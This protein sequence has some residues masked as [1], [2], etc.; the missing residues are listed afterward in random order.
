MHEIWVGFILMTP[1]SY[2]FF[3]EFGWNFYQLRKLREEI[4]RAA[5]RCILPRNFIV[6]RSSVS[7]EPNDGGSE[8]RRC[9]K[10]RKIITLPETNL[11]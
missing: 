11:T 2:G 5:Q 3:K 10:R 1:G 4:L 6:P 8:K 9:L 7:G